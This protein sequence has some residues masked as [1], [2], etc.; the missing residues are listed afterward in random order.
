MRKFT[1]LMFAALIVTG[2]FT[3]SFAQEEAAPKGK[4]KEKK[5][6]KSESSSDGSKVKD[7]QNQTQFFKPDMESQ[8]Y[9]FYRRK[10][11]STPLQPRYDTDSAV[12]QQGK[13]KTKQQQAYMNKQ[14]YFPAKPKDKWEMTLSL[15]SAIIGGDVRSTINPIQNFTAGLHVRKSLG[16]SLSVRF[17][18]NFAFMT[19]RNY[20]PDQNLKY[21]KALRGVGGYDTRVNYYNNPALVGSATSSGMDMNTKFFYNYRNLTHEAHLVLVANIGNIKFHRE[22]NFVNFYV[23]GGGSLFM[24]NTKMDALDGNGNVYDFSAPYSL[25]FQQPNPTGPPSV[26]SR[27]D[28]RKESLK[29]LKGILDGK[30]ESPAERDANVWGFKGNQIA[31]A[32]TLGGGID[33]HATKIF[34]IGLEARAIITSSDLLDGYRWTQDAYTSFTRDNDNYFFTTLRFN[35]QIGSKK[36]TESM[37]W[38][39]PMAHTYQKLG[40]ADAEA[41]KRDLMKD[42]DDDGVPNYL[43]K[44]PNTK[45]DCPVDV[46][47]VS[48]DN[49]KDGFIDCDDKE[50]FSPPGYPIDSFGVAIIPPNP[51]C[52]DADGT[53]VDGTGGPGGSGTGTGKGGRR[54]QGGYDCAKIELPGVTFDNDKYYVDPSYFGNLHQIAERM[55]LCPDMKLVVTGFDESKNDQKFNE[56]LAWN[57]ANATVDYLVEKYGISRDRFIVK[58]QGGK[59]AADGTEFEKKQKR[60]VDFRYAADGESGDSN[61][62][63]PHPGLKAGSNK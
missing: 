62:P 61:P 37:Y 50:P 28:R 5:E 53:G 45:K 47:G 27:N 2:G 20:V 43:D 7:S 9:N 56:Q 31:P 19:G 24:F 23:L 11:I 40:E 39:N 38:L 18:Y 34:T 48:L 52:D 21:N 13:Q 15:G 25:F 33:F 8:N 17:G 30:Y 1:R 22:R 6:K 4:Q 29:R 16:Y 54:G 46:R 49:D 3:Q 58:Y 44:E 35:F 10:D 26:N 57:R 42:D 32:F 55:Q 36:R 59:K 14:Y 63:A 60:K 51:C 41:V 12:Y